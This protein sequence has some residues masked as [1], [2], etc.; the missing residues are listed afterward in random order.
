MT[1]QARSMSTLFQYSKMN[2]KAKCFSFF[3][4]YISF[5][6]WADKAATELST[7]EKMTMKDNTYSKKLVFKFKIN[8]KMISF[9]WIFICRKLCIS[10]DL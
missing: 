8:S 3:H 10:F 7:Q 5:L 1:A 2:I 9:L 6:A 4:H